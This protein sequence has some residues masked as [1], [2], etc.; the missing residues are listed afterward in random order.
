MAIGFHSPL[1]ARRNNKLFP[2][3]KARLNWRVFIYSSPRSTT[4]VQ[5]QTMTQTLRLSARFLQTSGYPPAFAFTHCF[6]L[7]LLGILGKICDGSYWESKVM[8]LSID[9]WSLHS[10]LTFSLPAVYWFWCVSGLKLIFN[11]QH[12]WS[13]CESIFNKMKLLSYADEKKTKK[14]KS[15]YYRPIAW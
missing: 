15:M 10:T 12:R 11:W 3:L 9:N 7:L 4:R 2:I 14:K 5:T 8:Q 13:Y 1:R 6:L